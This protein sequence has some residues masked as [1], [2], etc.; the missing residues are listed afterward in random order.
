MIFRFDD[1]CLNTRM[2]HLNALAQLVKNRV[3]N[4]VVQYGVSLVVN[5]L[6][7]YRQPT[8]EM[9]FDPMYEPR[10]DPQ[11]Y[12]R[13]D[14]VGCPDD[15]P[16]GVEL[17][18]HGLI[19]VDHRLLSADAQAMS[20]AVSCSLLRTK[21]FTPPFHKWNSDTVF[22]CARH[23]IKLQKFEDGWLSAEHNAFIPSHPMWYAHSPAVTVARFREWLGENRA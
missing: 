19:H 3:P 13:V 5:E 16:P 1:V 12:F 20:I 6:R 8:D 21:I 14:K 11:C 9:V 7:G 23:G 2:R 10:S 17:T 22:A 15:I 4:A 18:S